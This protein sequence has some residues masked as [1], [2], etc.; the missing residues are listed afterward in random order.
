MSEEISDAEAI[1][2][3]VGCLSF[4]WRPKSKGFWIFWGLVILSLIQKERENRAFEEAWLKQG[5]T[6]E[7]IWRN[8]SWWDPVH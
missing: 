3:G 5:W 1:A 2:M 6:K 8:R 7:R 4:L